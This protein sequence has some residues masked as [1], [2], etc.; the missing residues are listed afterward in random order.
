M[1]LNVD[2]RMQR[3][4]ARLGGTAVIPCCSGSLAG[5]VYSVN[6]LC[7]ARGPTAMRYVME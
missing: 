7:P 5:S 4:P 1:R 3:E 6:S 2:T